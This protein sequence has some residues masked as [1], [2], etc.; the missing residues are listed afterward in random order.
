[1]LRKVLRNCRNSLYQSLLTR[2]WRDYAFRYFVAERLSNGDHFDLRIVRRQMTMMS[3][4]EVEFFKFI[5]NHSSHSHSQ[6]IQDLWALYESK[7][8]EN[9]FFVEFGATDGV[10]INNTLLL[11]REYGWT[12][13]LAEPNHVWHKALQENRGQAVC[14]DKRCVYGVSGEVLQ[15]LHTDNAEYG[16]V[17]DERVRG[18]AKKVG[19]KGNIIK[20]QTVSLNDLLTEHQAPE[21]VDFISMDTEGS[22]YEILKSFDFKKWD[23]RLF[24]IELG[25]DE[26]DQAISRLMEANGY[27]RRF[28]K[29]SSATPGIRSSGRRF[30]I[31]PPVPRNFT[32]LKSKG[33]LLTATTTERRLLTGR[34]PLFRFT[35]RCLESSRSTV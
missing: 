15:F 14:L 8:Q 22:E 34:D 13:I 16:A 21:R 19:M 11:E 29:F 32:Y 4:H 10:T 30:G 24:A 9:G 33:E 23:V 35:Q 27:R 6:A 28:E 7:Q 31:Y 17:V 20:V 1:M 2:L 12:G 25:T 3:T 18:A 26:K 5:I